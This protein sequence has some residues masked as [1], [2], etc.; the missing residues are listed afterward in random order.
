[1]DDVDPRKMTLAERM[2]YESDLDE[3]RPPGTSLIRP[4]C[5]DCLF[6]APDHYAC[7]AFPSGIPSSI[8]LN[9]YDHRRVYPGQKFPDIV[10]WTPREPDSVH[11]M[12]E[13]DDEP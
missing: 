10:L 4:Q 9:A 12:P 3:L 7:V 1:M 5:K 8:Q 2:Q 6:Y 13:D 11:P